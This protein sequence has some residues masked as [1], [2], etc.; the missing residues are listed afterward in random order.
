MTTATPKA[1]HPFTVSLKVNLST[2]I[3]TKATGL[4]CTAKLAG[5]VFKG[6][7]TGGCTIRVP[8]TAKGK[9]LVVKATG[10]Y[11]TTP[12]AATKTFKVS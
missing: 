11:K 1:G 10:K 5:K 12:V 4:K 8:K 9:S 2:G 3:S 7:G 6:S